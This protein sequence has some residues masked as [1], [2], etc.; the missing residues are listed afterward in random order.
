MDKLSLNNS[1]YLNQK[2]HNVFFKRSHDNKSSLKGLIFVVSRTEQTTYMSMIVIALIFLNGCAGLI[3]G[4]AV[5]AGGVAYH[6]GALKAGKDVTM[7]RAWSATVSAVNHLGFDVINK[8]KDAVSAR[9]EATTAQDRYV[10]IDLNR[11][12]GIVKFHIRI[13]TFGDEELSRTIFD[14]INSRL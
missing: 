14:E 4:A 7:D 11:E 2:I 3:A 1:S 5:G 13:D 6:Q 12:E 10:K 9:L 8:K